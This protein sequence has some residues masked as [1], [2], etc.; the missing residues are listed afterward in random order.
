MLAQAS[1]SSSGSG[2]NPRQRS[3]HV[4]AEFEFRSENGS[5]RLDVNFQRDFDRMWEWGE[6]WKF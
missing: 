2:V 5:D 6:G 1:G 4:D 3:A